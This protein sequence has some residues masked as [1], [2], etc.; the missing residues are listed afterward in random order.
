MECELSGDREPSE[1]GES[2]LCLF[3]VV[4][5]RTE[6]VP[7]VV[8]GTLLL[9]ERLLGPAA[10]KDGISKSRPW[11]L[12]CLWCTCSDRLSD[13]KA[14]EEEDEEE[15]KDE[16][17]TLKF[18]FFRDLTPVKLCESWLLLLNPL[19]DWEDCVWELVRIV[20]RGFLGC[21]AFKVKLDDDGGG[22]VDWLCFKFSLYLDFFPLFL[23]MMR[24]SYSNKGRE[25]RMKGRAREQIY[26][27]K[28]LLDFKIQIYFPRFPWVSSRLVGVGCRE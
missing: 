23:F 16:S 11:W 12:L 7:V 6:L 26:I 24:N 22:R 5:C 21:F 17:C 19:K 8:C 13:L 14:K 10:K 25:H 3:R 2:G 1:S 18:P 28:S 4:W 27:E 15:D 20:L 9:L